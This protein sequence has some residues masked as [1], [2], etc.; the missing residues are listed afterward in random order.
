MVGPA[1]AFRRHQLV[2]APPVSRPIPQFRGFRGRS[3][4]RVAAK[5][6]GL[7][8]ERREFSDPAPPDSAKLFQLSISRRVIALR[9]KHLEFSLRLPG[10]RRVELRA[11]QSNLI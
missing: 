10:S 6:S 1:C 3:F 11:R 8:Y 4:A 5:S 7:D 2:F 9:R